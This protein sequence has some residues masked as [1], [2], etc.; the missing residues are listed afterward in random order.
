MS[1]SVVRDLRKNL[2]VARDQGD[3]PT[4]VAFATSDAH[5]AGHPNSPAL[6]CEYAYFHAIRREGCDPHD[7]TTLKHILEAVEFDGQPIE[8]AWPYLPQ[9]PTDLST[10]K[11][12]ADVGLLRRGKSIVCTGPFSDLCDLLDQNV[13]VLTVLTISNA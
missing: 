1:I 8:T 9:L 5:A 12:P 7:G 4:C 11:P 2:G 10:W 3:R 13:P 6:S